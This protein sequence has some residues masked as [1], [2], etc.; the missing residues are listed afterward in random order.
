MGLG[1]LRTFLGCLMSSAGYHLGAFCEGWGI[2]REP[3]FLGPSICFV[4]GSVDMA[5]WVGE[6]AGRRL[7][8]TKDKS[9]ADGGGLNLVMMLPFRPGTAVTRNPTWKKP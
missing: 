4:L 3:P 9:N 6:Q 5:G 1:V 8:S 7:V 2:T